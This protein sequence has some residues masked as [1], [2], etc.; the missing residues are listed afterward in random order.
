[1]DREGSEVGRDGEKVAEMVKRKTWAG[2]GRHIRKC[3]KESAAGG[4]LGS[5][6]ESVVWV[7][8]GG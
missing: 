1:M 5:V 8:R 3:R 4:C 6:G 7:R 2:W